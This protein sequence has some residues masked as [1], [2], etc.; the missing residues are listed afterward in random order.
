MTQQYAQ[1][2]QYNTA[3]IAHSTDHYRHLTSAIVYSWFLSAFICK[4]IIPIL[5]V[6]L[7]GYLILFSTDIKHTVQH[8]NLF[9]WLFIF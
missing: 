9:V 1:E 3:N 4:V 5:G 7:L 2:F 8:W 6:I